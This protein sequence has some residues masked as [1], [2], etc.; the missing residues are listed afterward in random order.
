MSDANAA[1]GTA[2]DV[3]APERRYAARAESYA[4]RILHG[5]KRVVRDAWDVARFFLFALYLVLAL[6]SVWLWLAGALLGIVRFAVRA[7]MVSLLWLSGGL[8][9][10]P[11][12]PARSLAESIERD[13]QHLWRSRVVAYRRM[14]RGMAEHY[15]GARRATRTFW[16]WSVPRQLFAVALAGLLVAVPLAYIIPRPH[17]VQVTDDNAIHYT[18]DGQKVMYLVHAVD[19]FDKGQTREDINEDAAHL[20]KFNSQGLKAQIVPGRNYRFWVVGIRWWKYPQLFPNI[21]RAQVVD[22]EGNPIDAPSR[23]IPVTATGGGG[24]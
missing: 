8:A 20:A 3:P 15:I 5:G 17:Y 24:D 19:M 21:I 6:L 1:S 16:Y 12:A 13:L 4:S 18:D 23:L 22:A 10:R 2:H 7:L 11:G 9:P 14:S